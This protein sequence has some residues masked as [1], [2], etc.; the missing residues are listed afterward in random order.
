[1]IPLQRKKHNLEMIQGTKCGTHTHTH[2]GLTYYTINVLHTT[3][4]DNKQT[5]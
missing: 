5:L 4:T 1:M 3:E 2:G